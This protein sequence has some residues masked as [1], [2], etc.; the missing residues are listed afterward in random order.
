MK[1]T[2]LL[3]NNTFID[4]Y[5]L[6]EPGVSYFIEDNGKRILFDT[7][8]SDAFLR[9]AHRMKIDLLDLEHIVLSHGHLDHTWGLDSMVKLFTEAKIE[10]FKH[11]KPTVV[12]HPLVFNTKI[13]A[14]LGE[15]GSLFCAEK[16]SR[17]FKLQLSKEP[18]WLTENIVFLGEIPRI[19]DFELSEPESKVI[20]EE[21]EEEDNLVEDTA[22][23]VKTEKG[24]VIV[25]GCSHS[26]IC[27]MIEYAKNVCNEDRIIDVIG[28]FH[29]LRPSE[30][31]I[32][33]TVE[34]FRK[35]NATEV[36][37]CHCTDLTSRIKLSTV[38]ELKEVGSGLQL[39]Y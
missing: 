26:G 29:L 28:G 2:V 12:A 27:N 15:I 20:I 11:S 33:G 17:I 5:F 3:D 32:N 19:Y 23:A 38:C 34:Y 25:T 18:L 4:R 39:E 7:G 35:L 10:G 16:L 13:H 1:L 36:H 31:K 30:K 37:A 22:L 9:N 24:L 6:G 8:Y 14:D 21:K